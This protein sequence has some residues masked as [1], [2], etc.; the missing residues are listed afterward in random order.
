MYST[1]T[2][3]L[4][5]HSPMYCRESLC[6][7]PRYYYQAI[8]INVSASGYYS[9]ASGGDLSASGYLYN[10]TFD[11]SFFS[12]N[13]ILQNSDGPSLGR[14]GLEYLLQSAETYTVV[15]T[16]YYERDTGTF[17]LFGIGPASINYKQLTITSK[18]SRMIN[19]SIF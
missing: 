15:V 10:G 4:N 8:Q 6:F 3:A 7:E 19:V 18:N 12:Q 13:L 14:F 5:T 11:P 9:I 16:T 17:W 1:Y 2:S